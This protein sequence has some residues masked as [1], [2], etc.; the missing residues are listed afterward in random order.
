MAKTVGRIRKQSSFRGFARPDGRASRNGVSVSFRSRSDE[1]DAARIPVV[2][3]S[4]GRR[5]GGAVA[6]NRLRRRLGA[7]ARSAAPALPR[8]AYLVRADVSVAKLAFSDLELA[9][10]AAALSAAGASSPGT[11]PRS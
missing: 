2:A 10:R 1:A 8:G 5:H 9:L 11:E 3:Y 6:R 4:I 7:A